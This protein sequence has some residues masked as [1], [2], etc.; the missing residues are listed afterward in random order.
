MV[1]AEQLPDTLVLLEVFLA[2]Q[3]RS[4]FCLVTGR[5]KLL[6]L[7]ELLYLRLLNPIIFLK[8]V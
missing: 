8:L 7:C 1:I 6:F 3:A 4:V 2:Y 5:V